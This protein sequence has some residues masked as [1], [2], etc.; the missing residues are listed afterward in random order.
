MLSLARDDIIW[1]DV[2]DF[3][4]DDEGCQAQGINLVEF[5]GDTEQAVE[6]AVRRITDALRTD[7]SGG[8]RGFTV[9]HGE[10]DVG[11]IW[12]MRKKAVGLLGNMQGDKR[13]MPFVED[14]A[15][16]PENL[17]DYIAEFRDRAG[18]ARAGLRHVR[19]RRCRRACTFDRRST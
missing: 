19:S 12:E 14:T 7:G 16:P 2:R 3:F 9:A 5:V 17:A 18:P 15:V 8:R 4:P 1:D 11:R 10:T 6:A 13:P